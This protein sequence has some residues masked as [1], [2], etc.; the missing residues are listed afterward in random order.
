MFARDLFRAVRRSPPRLR[1][2]PPEVVPVEGSAL[3]GRTLR[4]IGSSE[5]SRISFVALEREGAETLI[6]PPGKELIRSGDLLIVAGDA[7]QVDALLAAAG[8]EAGERAGRL[9]A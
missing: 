4:E 8:G 2:H 3:V 7:D 5:A 9:S 6:P 1:R